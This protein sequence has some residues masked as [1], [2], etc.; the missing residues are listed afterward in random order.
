[1]ALKQIKTYEG[2]NVLSTKV[3]SIA[4]GDGEESLSM[5]IKIKAIEGSKTS[6]IAIVEFSNEKLKYL[7]R[8]EC[9]VSIEDNAP[10]NIKQAYQHLKTLPEFT[11]AIDC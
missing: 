1:M 8:Y 9:P 11:D 10:N 2:Q 7:S 5:Y 6:M 4:K 3:G